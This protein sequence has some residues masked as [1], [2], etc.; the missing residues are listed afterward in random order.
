[1][2]GSDQAI[3][4]KMLDKFY[5]ELN[6][7]SSTLYLPKLIQSKGYDP[8]SV[9][10]LPVGSLPANGGTSGAQQICAAVAPFGEAAI[11][12]PGVEPSIDLTDVSIAGLSN[13]KVD[14]PIAGGS[15]GRTITA[16]AEFLKLASPL[17]QQIVGKGNFTLK[18]QCCIAETKTTCKKG[19]APLNETGK[20]TFTFTITGGTAQVVLCI[21]KLAKDVLTLEAKSVEFKPTLPFKITV[22]ITSAPEKARQGFNNLAEGVLDTDKAQ[23][24][25]M[26][27]FN[28]VLNSEGRLD[29]F[30]KQLTEQLD[31]YLRDNHLYPFNGGFASLF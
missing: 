22:D 2:A 4:Q 16:T 8:D 11:P 13:V 24:A 12:T 7:P 28:A 20:G 5:P 15:D 6:D 14:R 23:T 27:Q 25:I 19:V 1:M 3:I 17:P 9:G 30:A 29:G 21:S 26:T 10:N 18:Q 31:D